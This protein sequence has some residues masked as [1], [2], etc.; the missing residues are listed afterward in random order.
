M[1]T[2]RFRSFAT[3][4]EVRRFPLGTAEVVGFDEITGTLIEVDP[5]WRWSTHIRDIMRTDTCQVHHVGYTLAGRMRVLTDDGEEAEVPPNSLYEIK[6]GHDAWVVG[7]EPWRAIEWTSGRIL[8]VAPEGPGRRVLVTLLL[9]DLVDS[10]ATLERLGDATWRDLLLTHN[11]RLRDQLNLY[12][13][14]EVTTTGDGMIAVF[15]SASR[16]VRCAAAMVRSA[17]ELGLSI[18]AGVHTGEVEFVG[19]DA[20]GLT[21]HAA[22][23]IMS[24]AAADEVLVSATTHGLLDGSGM[25]L[26][27]AGAYEMKGLTGARRVF[28]LSG[29]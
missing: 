26:E 22:S 19:T 1:A 14:R 29:G 20:Q 18:R 21:V 4:D 6:P 10:T 9:T 23:R 28:R 7:D 25:E 3:P 2:V 8:A 11:A 16:A 15:D 5:G 13:G 27:D 17:R 24:L 12:R